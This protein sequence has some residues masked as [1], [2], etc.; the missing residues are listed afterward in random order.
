VTT[1]DDFITLVRDEL[2]LEVTAEEVTRSLDQVAGWDSLHLLTLAT[3]LERETGRRLAL[4]DLMEADNLQ[5]I[6]AV[7][8]AA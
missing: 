5:G 3:A 7:A 8:T 6:Y 4:P 2:G 1:I